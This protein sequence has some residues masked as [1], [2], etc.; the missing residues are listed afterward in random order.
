MVKRFICSLVVANLLAGVTI[1]QSR[2]S[3]GIFGSTTTG[4]A[5]S[6]GRTTGGTM[7]N[8]GSLTNNTGSQGTTGGGGGGSV[9]TTSNTGNVATQ[10]VENNLANQAINLQQTPGQFVG[11]DS[12]DAVNLRSMQAAGQI[13]QGGQ[14]GLN[15]LQNLFSQS[16]QQLN[17]QTQRAA[18]PQIRVPLRIGFQPQSVS[19]A[20]VRRFETNLVKLPG[21]RFIGPPEVVMD[22]RTAILRGTVATEDDRQLAA[23]LAMMQP[24]VMA[25]R[26]ELQVDSSATTATG[27]PEALPPATAP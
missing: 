16:L 3:Q 14:G 18:R 22:G 25:V 15:Q 11:A 23:R 12:Q 19:L 21:I 13:G 5:A 20:H 26:N 24:E 17:Q 4:T 7:S 8:T 10:S 27:A 6:V 9:G 2:T 1:A